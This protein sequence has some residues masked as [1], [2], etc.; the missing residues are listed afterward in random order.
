MALWIKA[1][2][3]A[4]ESGIIALQEAIAP[5][6]VLPNG[7]TVGEW[8]APQIDEIYRTGEVPMLLPGGVE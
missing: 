4:A 6:A 3:E 7:R 2:L 1:L 8:L 5:Y